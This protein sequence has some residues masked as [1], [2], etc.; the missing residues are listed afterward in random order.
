MAID[1]VAS[2]T[3]A[4]DRREYARAAAHQYALTRADARRD[5][6]VEEARESAAQRPTPA[7]RA[8]EA[9]PSGNTKRLI[10]ILA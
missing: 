3:E 7:D 10:D 9:P 1:A 5:V 8:L 4:A 6:R 2:R